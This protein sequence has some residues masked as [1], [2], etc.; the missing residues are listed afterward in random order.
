MSGPARTPALDDAENLRHFQTN[1]IVHC[2]E[3]Q[4]VTQEYEV[5]E[6]YESETGSHGAH[7][8]GFDSTSEILETGLSSNASNNAHQNAATGVLAITTT[9][10]TLR[11]HVCQELRNELQYVFEGVSTD[12]IAEAEYIGEYFIERL[13]EHEGNPPT[14]LFPDTTSHTDALTSRLLNPNDEAPSLSA[15]PTPY[16]GIDQTAITTGHNQVLHPTREL[17]HFEQYL[18]VQQ[19][20]RQLRSSR[21]QGPPWFLQGAIDSWRHR[22]DSHSLLTYLIIDDNDYEDYVQNGHGSGSSRS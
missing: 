16:H 14:T 8:G 10:I 18:Q 20:S 11:N 1:P 4:K 12:R 15:L 6:G 22:I 7:I 21:G 13:R 17:L 5:D 19:I 2:D 3:P 9:S